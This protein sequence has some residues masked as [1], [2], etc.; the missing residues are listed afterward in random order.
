MDELRY[1]VKW[2]LDGKPGSLVTASEELA[3]RAYVVRR[4][5]LKQ[6]GVGFVS[7]S[8]WGFLVAYAASEGYVRPASAPVPLRDEREEVTA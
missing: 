2:S 4:G 5:L 7:L 1:R 6:G 3:R 8:E